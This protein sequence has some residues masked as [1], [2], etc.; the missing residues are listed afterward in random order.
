MTDDVKNKVC[1][2][3]DNQTSQCFDIE[4][5]VRSPTN[6][7]MMEQVGTTL[8]NPIE[9][10]ML[11][12]VPNTNSDNID[13]YIST[14]E[15]GFVN[16]SITNINKGITYDEKKLSFRDGIIQTTMT[17]QLGVG[18]YLLTI[19][20]AGN[21]Y[22]EP[23][24]FSLQFSIG[25]RRVECQF[26]NNVNGGYPEEQMEIPITLFD[27]LNNKTI[28]NCTINYTFNDV[29]YTTYTNNRGYANL[30]F[31]MP[32]VSGDYCATNIITNDETIIEEYTDDADVRLYWTADGNLVPYEGDIHDNIIMND[33]NPLDAIV[34][35]VID[36]DDENVL[37]INFDQESQMSDIF[38]IS[39]CDTDGDLDIPEEEEIEIVDIE[40]EIAEEENTKYNVYVYDLIIN[41]D[42]NVYDMEEQIVYLAIKKFNTQVIAYYTKD[43]DTKTIF[44][45]GDVINYDNYMTSN[46]EYGIIELYISDID[47]RRK[48]YIDEYGHFSFTIAYSEITTPVQSDIEPYTQFCSPDHP[49]QITIQNPQT[50][51]YRN[52]ETHNSADFL[53]LVTDQFTNKPISESMVTFVITQGQK[54]I[55]RYVTEVN[56]NG[57]AYISFDI[58]LV[59]TFSIQAFYHSMFNLLASESQIVEYTVK[60]IS[61]EE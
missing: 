31:P 2:R 55:Y 58:S 45:D 1:V 39:H 52:Y 27:A 10:D 60:D 32:K 44:I 24:L 51:F 3:I 4:E 19:D 46:V 20:Y 23:S 16:I 43:D 59:G 50:E 48:V 49:T 21:R 11:L 25:K 47:Y 13:D 5:L 22:Y 41:I 8:Y 56:E 53:A 26:H 6:I 36:I 18:D 7:I 54:E 42:N 30:T 61:E 34:Q 9:I 14:V 33:T 35:T 29:N 17:D 37:I 57:E 38:V 28:N 15:R 40:E 12:V